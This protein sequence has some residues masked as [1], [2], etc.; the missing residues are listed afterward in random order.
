MPERADP[1]PMTSFD[2]T[3]PVVVHEQTND[4]EVEWVPVTRDEWESSARWHDTARTVIAWKEMLLDWWWPTAEE[5]QAGE[6][7]PI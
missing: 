3:Q 6:R 4:V 1:Q 5:N 2:P 7:S